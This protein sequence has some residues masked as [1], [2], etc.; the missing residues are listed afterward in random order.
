MVVHFGTLEMKRAVV[1]GAAGA[2]KHPDTTLM[3]SYYHQTRPFL[4]T[5]HIRRARI[6]VSYTATLIRIFLPESVGS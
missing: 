5:L 1:F 2:V 3:A 6:F 4:V